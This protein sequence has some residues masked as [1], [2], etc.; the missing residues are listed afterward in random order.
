MSHVVADVSW[1][2]DR[3][4]LSPSRPAL[5][6]VLTGG[7]RERD[8]PVRSNVKLLSSVFRFL[9]SVGAYVAG[10]GIFGEPNWSLE[11][12]VSME[13]GERISRGLAAIN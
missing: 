1:S 9:F 8:C 5:A 3:P 11:Y 12:F 13:L 10:E 7:E 6:G 4:T 2:A